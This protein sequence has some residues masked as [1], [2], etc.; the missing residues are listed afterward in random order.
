M[1]LKK[2][3]THIHFK[4]YL[5]FQHFANISWHIDHQVFILLYFPPDFSSYWTNNLSLK[6]DIKLLSYF[7]F[8]FFL[9]IV[10]DKDLNQDPMGKRQALLVQSQ[11]R[12]NLHQNPHVVGKDHSILHRI[13][14]CSCRFLYV[15]YAHVLSNST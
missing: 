10:V 8:Y 3:L 6:I 15:F 4:I 12:S 5:T 7:Y 9:I 13:L 1:L 2:N 14:L 11:Y